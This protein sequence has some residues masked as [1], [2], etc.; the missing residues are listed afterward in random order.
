MQSDSATCHALCVPH[1]DAPACYAVDGGVKH[2]KTEALASVFLCISLGETKTL[3]RFPSPPDHP[4]L[5]EGPSLIKHLT[6]KHHE[7]SRTHKAYFPLM[8]QRSLGQHRR[9]R[10]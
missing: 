2:K 5:V 9:A 7:T 8:W 3:E 1:K 10:V 4:E 6:L